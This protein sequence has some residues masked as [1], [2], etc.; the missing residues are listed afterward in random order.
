MARG[1]SVAPVYEALKTKAPL[2]KMC[3]GLRADGGPRG[4]HEKPDGPQRTPTCREPYL[5]DTTYYVAADP[6]ITLVDLSESESEVEDD[7][8]KP[9]EYLG[10]HVGEPPRHRRV[11]V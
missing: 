6:G 10:S 5:P 7:V 2:N 11:F 4:M 3:D 9:R 1:S 8:V